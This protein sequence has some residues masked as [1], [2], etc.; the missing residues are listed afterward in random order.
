[1]I[2]ASLLLLVGV[3]LL[4]LGLLQHTLYDIGAVVVLIAGIGLAVRMVDVLRWLR[5]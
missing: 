3:G 1:M 2:A 4:A 5:H